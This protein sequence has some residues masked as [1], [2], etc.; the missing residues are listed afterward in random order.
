MGNLLKKNIAKYKIKTVTG[1][2]DYASMREVIYRRY[3]RVLKEGSTIARF[4]FD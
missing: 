1:P 3:S 2:D 4:N